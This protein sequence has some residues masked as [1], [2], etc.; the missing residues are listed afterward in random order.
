MWMNILES[1]SKYEVSENGLVRNKKTKKIIKSFDNGGYDRVKFSNG[2]K[3]LVHRL[4]AIYYIDNPEFK[5]QVNHKNLD[6][7]DNR[8]EN[9][10][11]VS[12]RENVNHWVSNGGKEVLKGNMS[13]VGK[14][15]GWI[16]VEAS[17]KPVICYYN[18]IEVGRYHSGREAAKETGSCYKKISSVCNGHRKTHNGYT[19]KFLEGVET[20][21]STPK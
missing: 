16:G 13:D 1:D 8:A 10:E 17:K 20:I 2:V 14:E 7:R 19:W 21:E 11:W 4:V 18:G 9:L 3:M 6:K 12:G 15:Y 5:S